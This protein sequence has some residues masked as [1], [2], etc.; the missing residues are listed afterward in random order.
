MFS[1]NQ[2]A[3]CT[4]ESAKKYI[5]YSV[6]KHAVLVFNYYLTVLSSFLPAK[7]IGVI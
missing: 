6:A 1:V 4:E 7:W 2:P 3:P 5:Q